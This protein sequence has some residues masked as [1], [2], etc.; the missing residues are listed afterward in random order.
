MF[1]TC[2]AHHPIARLRAKA[3]GQLP[4]SSCSS[5]EW[6]DP[7]EVDVD[8]DPFQVA[9]MSQAERAE[10]VRRVLK[11]YPHLAPLAPKLDLVPERPEPEADDHAG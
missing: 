10:L 4:L 6:P 1:Y 7:I 11:A 8:V 3:E 9:A 2:P 5:V